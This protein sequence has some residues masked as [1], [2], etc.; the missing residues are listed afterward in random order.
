MP[1]ST[2][3]KTT[4]RNHRAPKCTLW[5]SIGSFRHDGAAGRNRFRFT[6]RLGGR[7]TGLRGG[8]K[9]APGNYRVAA[10]ATDAAGNK[11]AEKHAK[12]RIA[13]R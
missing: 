12:F 5:T 3:V 10:V 2:C 8:G 4:G 7:V 1:G 13:R 9:L 11:S 6:G